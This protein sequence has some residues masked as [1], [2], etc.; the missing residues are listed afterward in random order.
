MYLCVTQQKLKQPVWWLS[1]HGTLVR[2]QQSTHHS[3]YSDCQRNRH[4]KKWKSWK[5]SHDNETC[6]SHRKH[7][8]HHGSSTQTFGAFRKCL[9]Q[10]SS[11][12][13]GHF[14][15]IFTAHGLANLDESRF[16]TNR[17]ARH[18]RFP[19][20]E[21]QVSHKI[22]FLVLLQ[23]CIVLVAIFGSKRLMS[24]FVIPLCVAK[25]QRQSLFSYVHVWVKL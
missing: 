25:Q 11:R 13:G 15:W 10:S 3:S 4:D 12:M 16:G 14:S 21:N 1:E 18:D 19:T 2:C 24:F 9:L 5:Q 6:C 7:Y 20:V 17:F 22:W 8:Q 23:S